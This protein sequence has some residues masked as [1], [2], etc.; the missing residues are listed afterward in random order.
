M[1]GIQGIVLHKVALYHRVA[2]L[3]LFNFHL[4]HVQCLPIIGRKVE[5]SPEVFVRF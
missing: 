3:Q 4:R 1:Q 5:A 2:S